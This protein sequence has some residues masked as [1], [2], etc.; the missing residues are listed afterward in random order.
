[1]AACSNQRRHDTETQ[2]TVSVRGMSRCCSQ[3][4][5]AE[6]ERKQRQPTRHRC[7][8]SRLVISNG[9]SRTCAYM[10]S[11]QYWRWSAETR[12]ASV[13]CRAML[14]WCVRSARRQHQNWIA[15]SVRWRSVSCCNTERL[16]SNTVQCSYDRQPLLHSNASL[17]LTHTLLTHTEQ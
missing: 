13:E 2:R 1:M 15:K 16:M 7:H 5:K 17:K 4:N 6:R 11:M 12:A 3:L 14:S 8:R 10:S 9:Y